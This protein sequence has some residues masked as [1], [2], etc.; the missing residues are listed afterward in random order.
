MDLYDN[1][2]NVSLSPNQPSKNCMESP[3][4][5]MSLLYTRLNPGLSSAAAVLLL[6]SLQAVLYLTPGDRLSWVSISSQS[7]NCPNFINAAPPEHH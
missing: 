5:L 7:I 6:A 2:N 4:H 1:V 3:F